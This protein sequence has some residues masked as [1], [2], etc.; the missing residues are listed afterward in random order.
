MR[1][2]LVTLAADYF[3][4]HGS[5]GLRGTGLHHPR[6][7]SAAKNYGVCPSAGTTTAGEGQVLCHGQPGVW[8]CLRPGC[9]PWQREA[10]KGTGSHD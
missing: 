8:V 6:K 3:P 10:E 5:L 2:E 1:V 9:F 7:Q 4:C